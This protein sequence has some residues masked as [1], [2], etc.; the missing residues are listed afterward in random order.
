M[1]PLWLGIELYHPA[2]DPVG[3][4]LG[5]DRAIKRVCK[6]DPLAIAADLDHLRAAVQRAILGAFGCAALDTMPP[7]RTLP[8]SFGL[9]GSDTSYCCRSPVPQQAT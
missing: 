8:V 9:N 2:L 6:V 1:P 3:I 5:V 4:E 7:M